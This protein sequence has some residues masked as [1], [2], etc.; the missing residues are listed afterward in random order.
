MTKSKS[1]FVILFAIFFMMLWIIYESWHGYFRQHHAVIDQSNTDVNSPSANMTLDTAK[2]EISSKI[3]N[4]NIIAERKSKEAKGL[5]ELSLYKK[6]MEKDINID[7][8]IA[9]RMLNGTMTDKDYEWLQIVIAENM[10]E[11]EN[12]T[13]E[14]SSLMTFSDIKNAYDKR[15]TVTGLFYGDAILENPNAYREASK[16]EILN[17]LNQGASLPKDALLHM[18]TA[19]NLELAEQLIQEGYQPDV[20]YVDEYTKMSLLEAQSEIIT[21]NPLKAPIEKQVESFQKLIDLGVPISNEDG[22]R[23]ALDRILGATYATN[24]NAGAERLMTLAV[25]LNQ[26]GLPLSVSHEQLLEK[27]KVKY[28]NIYQQG[29]AKFH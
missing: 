28:P 24:D 5:N 3:N 29:I 17:I 20:H 25:K 16:D 22:T 2:T 19:D 9:N 6:L 11:E 26:M 7:E 1:L 27:I 8:D 4:E 13:V 12:F 10:S 15:S 23:D 14:V 18:I 21:W